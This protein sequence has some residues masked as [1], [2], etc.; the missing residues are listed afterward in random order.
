MTLESVHHI[1]SSQPI[2]VLWLTHDYSHRSVPSV[3]DVLLVR[4]GKRLT[5]QSHKVLAACV[6][7]GKA[8]AMNSSYEHIHYLS[9][10]E[11]PSATCV[12]HSKPNMQDPQAQLP[13]PGQGNIHLYT[14]TSLQLVGS[15]S[16]TPPLAF[17]FRWASAFP[18]LRSLSGRTLCL[19]SSFLWCTDFLLL[20]R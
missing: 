12:F 15:S 13:S 4:H 5:T 18:W 7:T 14:E 3:L 17:R 16:S 1:Q 20:L 2:S 19:R 10:Y 9:P 11:A 6:Q 8:L